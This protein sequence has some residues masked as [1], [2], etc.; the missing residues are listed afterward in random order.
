MTGTA[1][2]DVERVYSTADVVAKLR[3]LADALESETSFRIQI[4]GERFRVP[5]RAQFS[6]E[7]ERGDGEEEVE[8]QLKWKIEESDSDD[9]S[10]GT[11]V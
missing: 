10:E 2:R 4:A 3:R 5:A 9:D 7:H 6:I 11:V 8:F 1:P